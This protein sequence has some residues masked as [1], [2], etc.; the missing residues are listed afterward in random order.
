MSDATA[1]L[2]LPFILPGQAQKE[3]YHNESLT[4]IDIALHAAVESAPLAAPPATP[5]LGQTWIVAANTSGIWS[6]KENNLASWSEGGWR[7]IEPTP[8][9][10]AWNKTAGHWLQWREGGWSSGELS[11]ASYFVNGKKV[12]GERQP[13]VPSPSGGTIIDEEARTAIAALTASLKSHGLID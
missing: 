13:A 4:R 12:V 9:M 1:R 2:A 10:L 11:A 3:F 5:A 6:E 8:G 7:F